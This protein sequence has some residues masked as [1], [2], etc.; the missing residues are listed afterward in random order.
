MFFEAISRCVPS[1]PIRPSVVKYL[2]K[3]HNLWHR[4]VLILENMA[5]DGGTANVLQIKPKFS[6]SAEF[7]FEPNTPNTAVQQVCM[8]SAGSRK[9]VFT[10]SIQRCFLSA[11]LLL[12][13]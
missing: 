12:W 1:L 4:A 8:F 2:G 7:D 3:S 13:S 6:S 10:A 11:A 5:V 9:S